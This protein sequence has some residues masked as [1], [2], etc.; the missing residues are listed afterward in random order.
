MC[1]RD[2]PRTA[3]SRPKS[4]PG[5]PVEAQERLKIANI[6]PKSRPSAAMTAYRRPEDGPEP[7]VEAQERPKIANI[8]PKTANIGLKSGP[9][10]HTEAPR[11]T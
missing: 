11:A 5:S 8:G 2:R 9:G 7:S 10:P 6:G 3:H 4:G 1:I